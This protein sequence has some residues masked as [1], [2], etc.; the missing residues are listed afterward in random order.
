MILKYQ[1]ATNSSPLLEDRLRT[2][3]QR[4]YW[5]FAVKVHLECK[6][7]GSSKKSRSV[8]ITNMYAIEKLQL[9]K[10]TSGNGDSATT[11]LSR[12]AI[13]LSF[14]LKLVVRR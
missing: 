6:L 5:L 13:V 9:L 8:R 4:I 10:K 1:Y 7:E 2:F 14:Q 12:G 3:S 11:V